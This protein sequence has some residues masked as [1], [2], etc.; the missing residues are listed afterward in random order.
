MRMKAKQGLCPDTDL[1]FF[2]IINEL[3]RLPRPVR[4]VS[5]NDRKESR[6]VEPRARTRL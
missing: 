2:I 1:M 6:Q 5:H 4:E 3:M